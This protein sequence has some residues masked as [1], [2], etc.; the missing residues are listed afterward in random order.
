MGKTRSH[1]WVLGLLLSEA[2]VVLV[3]RDF[4][5]PL[6]APVRG[7]FEIFLPGFKWASPAT[8]LIGVVESFL[9]GAYLEMMAVPMLRSFVAKHS[10]HAT[11][12]PS[13]HAA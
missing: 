8:F 9:W 5:S 3:L 2:F 10:H 7:A 6:S 4:L 1:C 11:A 12:H 13:H